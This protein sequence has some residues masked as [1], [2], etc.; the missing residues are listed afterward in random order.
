MFQEVI[1][2]AIIESFIMVGAA[3]ILATIIGFGV[4]IVLI[5]SEEG[6]LIPNK[7]L[8]KVLDFVVNLLRSFP[9]FI[10]MVVISPLTKAIVG[11]TTG[12]FAAIVPLTIGSAP[13]AARLIESSLK[14]VDKG[15]VEAAKSMG[16]TNSQIIFKVLLKEAKP[17]LSSGITLLIISIIGYSA[18]AGS[19]GA[20]G[21][22]D[23]AVNYGYYR[24]D[25]TVM[26]VTVIVLIILVQLIQ[27][28]GNILYKKLSK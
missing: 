6:G 28:I 9:F 7:I 20:G 17:A 4:A 24:F 14:A 5:I 2:P 13:F 15:V 26:V 12:T 23:V 22:G 27:T 25:T 16:A 8:Y 18:M 10:L 1:L 3:T 19:I 11:R 21:L